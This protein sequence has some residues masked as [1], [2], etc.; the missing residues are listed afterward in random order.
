MPKEAKERTELQVRMDDAAAV[1]AKELKKLPKD[2]VKTVGTW[3][4][5]NR[6][7]AGLKRLGRVLIEATQPAAKKVDDKAE[8]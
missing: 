5:A 4:A 6:S 3:M 8:D 2:A 1:A 7:K